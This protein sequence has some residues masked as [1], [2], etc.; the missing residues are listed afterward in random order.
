MYPQY[1]ALL[2]AQL[3]VTH[4]RGNY[5]AKLNKRTMSSNYCHYKRRLSTKLTLE[6]KNRCLGGASTMKAGNKSIV[7]TDETHEM[8]PNYW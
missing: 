4:T 5:C 6:S 8:Y 1:R 7:D 2:W 3:T